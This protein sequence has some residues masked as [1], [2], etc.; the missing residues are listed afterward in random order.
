M[1]KL[2]I[3]V[4]ARQ[5]AEQ[6]EFAPDEACISV[7]SAGDEPAILLIDDENCLRLNFDDTDWIHSDPPGPGEPPRMR[8]TSRQAG[9]ILNFVDGRIKAG[10]LRFVVH[11]D[12]GISRSPG[13]AVALKEIYNKDLTVV[14]AHSR[15]S[16][17]VRETLLTEAKKRPDII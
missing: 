7:Y 2:E 1:K 14:P 10:I 8:F 4:C 17:T 3:K 11:C 12:G 5:E 16:P 15:Y 6:L 9:E 13:I